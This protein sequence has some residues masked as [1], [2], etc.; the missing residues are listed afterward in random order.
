MPFVPKLGSEDFSKVQP[1]TQYIQTNYK[2]C[3]DIEKLKI[4]P[5]NK[6]EFDKWYSAF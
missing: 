3:G 1:Y 4:K 6:I 2:E 5:E